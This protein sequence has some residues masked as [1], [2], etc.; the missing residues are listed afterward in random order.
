MMQDY[1]NRYSHV[2]CG[3]K[4]FNLINSFSLTALTPNQWWN[5][6]PSKGHII[7]VKCPG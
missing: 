4:N 5:N 1:I 3:D 7:I 6:P 2:I